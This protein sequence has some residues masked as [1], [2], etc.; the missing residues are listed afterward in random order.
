MNTTWSYRY[1]IYKL[2]G[3]DAQN[4]FTTIFQ[5]QGGACS[6]EYYKRMREIFENFHIWHQQPR[7]IKCLPSLFNPGFYLEECWWSFQVPLLVSIRIFQREWRKLNFVEFTD[8][9]WFWSPAKYLVRWPALRMH[10]NWPIAVIYKFSQKWT[11]WKRG[12]QMQRI[13]LLSQGPDSLVM[14]AVPTPCLCVQ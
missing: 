1:N 9:S 12:K 2:C 6:L 4:V 10:T 8:Q 5:I 3:K 14:D 13:Q 7:S 11:I